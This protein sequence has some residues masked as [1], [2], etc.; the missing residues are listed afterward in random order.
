MD[1]RE[2]EDMALVLMYDNGLRGWCFRFNNAVRTF[3]LCDY[4]HR[5]ISLSSKLVAINEYA[6]VKN[7]IL[8]EIAHALAGKACGHGYS[9]ARM[10]RNIGCDAKRC[11]S[12]ENTVLP[13]MPWKATCGHCGRTYQ[14]AR[15]PKDVACGECCKKYNFGKFTTEFKLVFTRN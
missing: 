11:Y 9:W 12:S 13:K 4:T 7:T 8:H 1:L 6:R 2:A 10:A 14:Y 5:T 3:G 15:R